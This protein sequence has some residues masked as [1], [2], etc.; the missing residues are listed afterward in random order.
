MWEEKEGT[1]VRE[2]TFED[3]KGALE[4][5]DKVGAA[6]EAVQHHPDICFGWGKAKITLTTHDA[7]GVTDKDRA[8]AKT[9]DTM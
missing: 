2:F 1:L 3:F 4:F 8:L 7:G 6:A 5:V 9:I